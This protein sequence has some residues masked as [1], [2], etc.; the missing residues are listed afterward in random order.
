[1]PIQ[2]VTNISAAK[3][4]LLDSWRKER[5]WQNWSPA[6]STFQRDVFGSGFLTKSTK[7]V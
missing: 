7:V 6:M 4:Y 1:M 2:V 3:E 5:R